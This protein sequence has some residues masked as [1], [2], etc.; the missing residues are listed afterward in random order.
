MIKAALFAGI[1]GIQDRPMGVIKGSTGYLEDTFH[2]HLPTIDLS[3]S[4]VQEA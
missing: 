4:F 3:T 1:V 2:A